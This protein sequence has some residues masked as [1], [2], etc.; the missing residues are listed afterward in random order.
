MS[1]ITYELS[2]RQRKSLLVRGTPIR[3]A[4]PVPPHAI[5]D[6]A[7]WA[8]SVLPVDLRQC[9][10]RAEESEITVDPRVGGDHLSGVLGAIV[11]YDRDQPRWLVTVMAVIVEMSPHNPRHKPET[12]IQWP[13]QLRFFDEVIP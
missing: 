10:V 2:N 9:V 1:P 13:L 3:I 7:D 6:P 12:A 5:D 11:D 4:L 8:R